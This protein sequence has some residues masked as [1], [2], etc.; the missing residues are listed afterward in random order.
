MLLEETP[1]AYIWR[2]IAWLPKTLGNVDSQYRTVLSKLVRSPGLLL[3]KKTNCPK[4]SL[5]MKGLDRSHSDRL[6]TNDLIHQTVQMVDISQCLLQRIHERL[7]GGHR[8]PVVAHTTENRATH[9]FVAPAW[10]LVLHDEPSQHCRAWRHSLRAR[11]FQVALVRICLR[12]H[13]AGREMIL[14]EYVARFTEPFKDSHQPHT[15]RQDSRNR[16]KIQ[17]CPE[18]NLKHP[19]PDPMHTLLPKWMQIFAR[20]RP[21]AQA[22]EN[23]LEVELSNRH[24][25]RR[26]FICCLVGSNELGRLQSKD[27]PRYS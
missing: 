18:A 12:A 26:I 14:P 20:Y 9:H 4:S 1:L 22:Q 2:P 3:I 13:D 5:Q 25:T 27:L 21:I 15:P 11:I 6:N 24:Q 7:K 19:T 8:D 16:R 10:T 23:V 17:F